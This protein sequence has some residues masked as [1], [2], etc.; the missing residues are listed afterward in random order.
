[1]MPLDGMVIEKNTIQATLIVPLY[2]RKMCSEKF[3][4]FYQDP[5]ARDLCDKLAYD[6]SDL[7]KKEDSFL[8]EFGALEAAMRQLDIMWEIKAYLKTYPQATIVNL[9][10]GLDETFM[11]HD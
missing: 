5:F 11:S 3:P 10:C 8:Y 4:K 1:M 7:E 6:F 9:G 2:G